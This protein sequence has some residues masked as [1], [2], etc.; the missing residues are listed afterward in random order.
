MMVR[1]GVARMV[2]ASLFFSMM[3]ALVKHVA[4]RIDTFEIIVFRCV[5]P[6][7]LL[8]WLLH[9]RKISLLPRKPL[10]LLVRATAGITAMSLFFW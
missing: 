9:Q 1:S 2:L 5:L 8:V 6:L 3:A 10:L 4:P 7:P